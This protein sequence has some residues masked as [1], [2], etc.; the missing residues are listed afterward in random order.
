MRLVASLSGLFLTVQ[1]T[2]QGWQNGNGPYMFPVNDLVPS[3]DGSLLYV[4]AGTNVPAR[5]L[6]SWDGI[7]WSGLVT[8]NGGNLWTLAEDADTLYIGG[9]FTF[10]DSLPYSMLVRRVNNQWYPTASFNAGVTSVKVYGDTVLAVG[11]FT[12]LNGQPCSGMA[13]AVNGVWE[14]LADSG[15]IPTLIY[16]VI[17]HHDTLFVAGAMDVTTGPGRGIIYKTTG[18]WQ[19]LGTG[20]VGM[21]GIGK[22]LAVYHDQLYIG[23]SIYGYEGN[24]ANGI[25]RWN[26]TSLEAVGQP[27]LYGV[28]GTINC[29][30]DV[31]DM[32]VHDD[33]LFV[34]GRF[35]YV[36]GTPVTGVAYWDGLSWCPLG[37]GLLMPVRSLAFFQDTLFASTAQLDGVQ[38]NGVAKYIADT[39][40]AP[41]STT[42][43]VHAEGPIQLMLWPVPCNERLNLS[44][45]PGRSLEVV[46]RDAMGRERARHKV[47]G[48]EHE[49]DVRRLPAGAYTIEFQGGTP[50][51]SRRFVKE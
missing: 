9:A 19:Q 45:L 23:G 20:F 28:C 22:T 51:P 21:N 18:P 43:V 26:G 27:T 31:Y 49:L 48:T 42:D 17:K 30:C 35:G 2:A 1:L 16:D 5:P 13:M 41:C 4:C 15:A 14:C 47:H 6:F 7:A 3:Q 11:G 32:V 25:A 34:S 39:T 10:V 24:V 40:F 46:V 33:K 50:V 37:G 36:N 29:P 38:I 8:F 44:G 12:E